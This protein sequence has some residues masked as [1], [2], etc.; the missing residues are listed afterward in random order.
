MSYPRP[1]TNKDTLRMVELLGQKK[2]HE[3]I[4]ADLGRH[5]STIAKRVRAYRYI[6]KAVAE[7]AVPPR[8]IVNAAMRLNYQPSHS[9]SGFF[10]ARVLLS[11][12]RPTKRLPRPRPDQG[13]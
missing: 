3:E 2:T 1:W 5:P 7:G 9:P 11:T 8:T 6:S 13:C 4:A 12:Q 10:V